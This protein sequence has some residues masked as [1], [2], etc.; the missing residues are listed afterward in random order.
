MYA[1]NILKQHKN[2][3]KQFVKKF[4]KKCIINAYAYTRYYNIIYTTRVRKFK[5][6]YVHRKNNTNVRIIYNLSF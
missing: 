2:T 6:K 5:K 1:V 4:K 3:K